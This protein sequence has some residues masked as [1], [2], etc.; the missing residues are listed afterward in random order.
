MFLRLKS[1]EA[2]V[3]KF[4]KSVFSSYMLV[5]FSWA[6][7]R[8]KKCFV[9]CRQMHVCSRESDKEKYFRKEPHDSVWE[10]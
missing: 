10:R 3:L 8:E 4:N 6:F 5:W 7:I 1:T 2:V 9:L